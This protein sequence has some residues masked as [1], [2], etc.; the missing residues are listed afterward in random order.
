MAV[1]KGQIVNGTLTDEQIEAEMREHYSS[2]DK[3]CFVATLL[4]LGGELPEEL[5]GS[6]FDGPD[7]LKQLVPYVQEIEG[8]IKVPNS[9]MNYMG[10]D[11]KSWGVV[12][13]LSLLYPK[14]RDEILRGMYE[15]FERGKANKAIRLYCVNWDRSIILKY[16]FP[17]VGRESLP[18]F[19]KILEAIANGKNDYTDQPYLAVRSV[20]NL[21][22]CKLGDLGLEFRDILYTEEEEMKKQTAKQKQQ[23]ATQASKLEKEVAKAET[24]E[25]VETVE[26]NQQAEEW[27]T[28]NEDGTITIDEK[29]AEEL[30]K[31]FSE[32]LF[33]EKFSAE[34]IKEQVTKDPKQVA[35]VIDMCLELDK[36]GMANLS[37]QE[38]EEMSKVKAALESIDAEVASEEV[39]SNPG[40]SW[41]KDNGWTTTEKVVAGVAGAAVVGGI[42]YGVYRYLNRDE[43]SGFVMNY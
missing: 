33:K 4:S 25:K 18:A 36:L 35:G 14:M 10:Y 28:T 22:E 7:V 8:I 24:T 31:E 19:S 29:T 32:E 43:T 15:V 38:K 1:K 30:K 41:T 42:A 40:K 5:K 23:A 3:I 16:N 12:V 6:E 13:V 39:V 21:P 26:A 11:L 20:L 37:D 34:K 9:P 27:Y 17:D 2:L